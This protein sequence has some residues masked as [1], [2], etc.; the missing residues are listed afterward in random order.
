MKEIKINSVLYNFE[1]DTVNIETTGKYNE[2]E[3]EIE[4]D[5]ENLKVKIKIL[6]N[7]KIILSRKNDDY[8]INLEFQEENRIKCKYEVKS[9]GLNFEV[10]VLLLKVMV[11]PLFNII[12]YFEFNL[13]WSS[14]SHEWNNTNNIT[15]VT[16]I[17]L[18]I[19]L[20]LV[21]NYQRFRI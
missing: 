19:V 9:I 15:E 2:K 21:I 16:K 18:V 5:E 13:Y 8:N 6:D 1:N 17:N 14:F 12:L 7:K 3:K 20:E 11:S 10:E 4:Y